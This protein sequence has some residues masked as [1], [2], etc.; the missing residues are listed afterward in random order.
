MKPRWMTSTGRLIG[1][2]VSRLVRFFDFLFMGWN[3]D[4]VLSWVVAGWVVVGMVQIERLRNDS[5]ELSQRLLKLESPTSRN[6]M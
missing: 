5:K 1:V 2:A 6:P 3:R 4:W